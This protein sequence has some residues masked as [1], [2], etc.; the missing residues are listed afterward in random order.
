[1]GRIQPAP[2]LESPRS[3]R[4]QAARTPRREPDPAHG[5]PAGSQV[6]IVREGDTLYSLSRRYGVPV[7]ELVT[8]NRIYGGRIE[9]G[10][11]LTVPAR[12]PSLAD[13]RY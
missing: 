11:R 6:V 3:D 5:R 4:W 1:M 8:A 2:P 10:Q 9:V 7:A 13:R 12:G